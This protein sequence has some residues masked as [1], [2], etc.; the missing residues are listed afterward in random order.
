MPLHK[1]WVRPRRRLA[2]SALIAAATAALVAPGAAPAHA[3]WSSC[4]GA[5]ALVSKATW[6][7]H[8]LATGVVLREGQAKDSKGIVDMHVLQVD[9]TK[10][11]LYFG[12]LIKH[13][14]QRS[15][16][17]NLAAGRT[18]LVA[19]TNTGY[20]DFQSG[21]PT[22]PVIQKGTFI[23]GTSNGQSVVGL[24]AHGR[25]QSGNVW[26]HGHAYSGGSSY[27]V[28]GVN[29]QDPPDG[30]SVYTPQWGAFNVPLRWNS[31]SRYIVGGT[32]KTGAGKQYDAVHSTGTLVVANG[33][34]A[35]NWLN[36]LKVGNPF[37]MKISVGTKV[38]V[39]FTQAYGVGLQIVQKAGVVRNDLSCRYPTTQP[40]RTAIGWADSGRKLIIAVVA[41][42]PHANIHGLD[43]K[44]MSGLMV[45]LGATR[46]FS[47]DGSGSSE[48][49]ARMPGTSKLSMRN[50]PADGAERPMP[51][52][53]GIFSR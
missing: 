23:T 15:P 16:L 9:V 18:R 20:F 51:V 33:W 13:V 22:A 37:T 44:Q 7:T 48:L 45:Q 5:E 31:V 52:G 50:Y 26:V 6:H 43:Q 25:F 38:T 28:V 27:R 32:I 3:G 49:L 2:L 53:F 11:N 24:N 39:P 1:T 41:D 35:K 47:F 46:A 10:P 19:A 34:K 4:P 12:P 21:V 14:A 8:K 30:I 17:T 29:A 40:A 42:H 36:G